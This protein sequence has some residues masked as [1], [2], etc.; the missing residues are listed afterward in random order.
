MDLAKDVPT[1]D[2]DR[3]FIFFHQRA[4]HVPY[5]DSCRHVDDDFKYL[6]NGNSSYDEQ[7]KNEY[8]VGPRCWDKNI[9]DIV[10]QL[11]KRPGSLY[12]F[13]TA[14]HSE[15]MGEEGLFGHSHL[16]LRDSAV[17]FILLTNRPTSEVAGAFRDMS[18]ASF[19]NLSRVVALALGNS[20][21]E[22]DNIRGRFLWEEHFHLGWMDT[23]KQPRRRLGNSKLTF[24]T[25]KGLFWIRK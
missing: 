13:V 18:P 25:Q 19:F 8:S 9:N 20:I 4:P 11:S 21:E 24:L 2:N 7:R 14:D 1:I 17:P 23:C 12:I 6:L 10:N 22:R 15:L 5:L 3:A 16:V